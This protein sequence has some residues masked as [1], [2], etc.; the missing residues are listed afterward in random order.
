MVNG[1][2]NRLSASNIES[3]LLELER[4]YRTHSRSS[5]NTI[6]C[7]AM[8]ILC[9]NTV[10]VMIPMI[11]INTALLTGLFHAVGTSVGGFALEYFTTALYTVRQ[12]SF[13]IG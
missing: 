8:T 4:L 13:L 5:L 2:L 11:T 6:L 3:V 10:Q 1:Q 7:D 9:G 12:R